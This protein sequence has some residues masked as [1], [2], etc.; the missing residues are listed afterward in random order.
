MTMP[1]A[2]PEV[3]L[4][5]TSWE[6]FDLARWMA[7]EK[8][9]L[10][11]NNLPATLSVTVTCA[12]VLVGMLRH[13]APLHVLAAW[14]I[15]AILISLARY[16]QYLVFR[17]VSDGTIDTPLWARK[18][19]VGT[20]MSGLL[21]GSTA[22]VLFP[23]GDLAHQVLIAFVLAG[24]AAGAMTS[25]A[26]IW[27]CYVLFVVPAILPFVCR[28]A[29]QNT[30]IHA[31]MALLG[32]IFVA[33]V[34]RAATQTDKMINNVL[35]VRAENFKL[36]RAL[37]HQATHDPLVD[38]PNQREFNRRLTA[39]AQS[40]AARHEPF[41]LLFVDLDR[42]KEIND[43]GGHA[44]GDETLRRVS[45]LVKSHLRPSDTVARMG[46][47]EFAVL[48]PVCSREAAER[49]AASL[50]V[51]IEEFT[52]AWE[53]GR[54]FRVSAS[55]GLAYA[56]PGEHDTVALLRAADAACYAAKIGGR[57]RI[58]AYR[59]DSSFGPSGRSEIS[60][61]RQQLSVVGGADK[62]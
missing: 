39:L 11:W 57:G 18:L 60:R 2:S 25:Y 22:V 27:R 5:T 4:Q 62:S 3:G 49:I 29:L 42:F 35:S 24:L 58:K 20:A 1:I 19:H 56:E 54:I 45:Q 36:T 28:L 53:N 14:F 13:V 34:V 52:L 55:I 61:L 23:I 41:A 31:S 59:A 26:V 10:V 30:E 15:V 6:D 50:L 17:R 16:R 12:A 7:L 32:L 21:W 8:L 40:S 44:A 37:H 46:G 48:L 9:R 33:A 38:L 43:T 51:T 47:D